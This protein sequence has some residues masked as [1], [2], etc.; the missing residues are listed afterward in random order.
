[1]L[2]LIIPWV[3]N[4]EGYPPGAPP[5]NPLTI[6]RK[7]AAA[8]LGHQHESPT[9]EKSPGTV[10]LPGDRPFSHGDRPFDA[11]DRPFLREDRPFGASTRFRG[12]RQFP[13]LVPVQ[14]GAGSI[15]GPGASAALL[16]GPLAEYPVRFSLQYSQDLYNTV[17][18]IWVKT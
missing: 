8:C 18:E 3:R 4:P 5:T 17:C 7:S 6:A 13:M 14:A 10:I 9:G 11:R 15:C 2:S 16:G 12:F 1:M